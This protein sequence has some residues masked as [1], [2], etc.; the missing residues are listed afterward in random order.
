MNVSS[1]RSFASQTLV[2]IRPSESDCMLVF[3][4]DRGGNFLYARELVQTLPDDIGCYGMRIPSLL[5]TSDEPLTFQQIC[6][7]LARDLEAAAGECRLHLAG[8]SFAGLLAFETARALSTGPA[9]AEAVWLFDTRAHRL[10]WTS[11]FRHAPLR[12]T[13]RLFRY[14]W[15]NWQSVIGLQKDDMMLRHPRLTTIDLMTHHVSYH[16]IMRRL[17]TAIK[18]YKPKPWRSAPVTLFRADKDDDTLPP[19]DLGWTQLTVGNAKFASLPGTHMTILKDPMCCEL[20][21]AKIY[22]RTREQAKDKRH[23]RP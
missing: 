15:Q 16:Q 12:E 22:N 1:L 11:M 21:V 8:F 23:G 17:Y 19:F 4:P 2:P 6:A 9:A 3:M 5:L 10:H 13:S 20:A 18:T 7:E 14:F